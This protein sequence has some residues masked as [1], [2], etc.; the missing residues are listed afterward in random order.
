VKTAIN[1]LILALSEIAEQ[2]KQSLCFVTALRLE[3]FFR[4]INAVQDGGRLV[5]FRW[6]YRLYRSAQECRDAVP[7]GFGNRGNVGPVAAHIAAAPSRSARLPHAAPSSVPEL[8][9]PHNIT[10]NDLSKP[11]IGF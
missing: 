3:K 8:L 9:F 4:L 6:A 5:T 1:A 7:A 11:G 10:G 2:G